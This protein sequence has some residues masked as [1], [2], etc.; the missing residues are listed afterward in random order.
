[1]RAVRFLDGKVPGHIV[2]WPVETR[3]GHVDIQ[4]VHIARRGAQGDIPEI[5]PFVGHIGNDLMA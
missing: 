1:M 5:K 4:P 3:V 2:V